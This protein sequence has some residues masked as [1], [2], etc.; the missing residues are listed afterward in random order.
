MSAAASIDAAARV[1]EEQV[2]PAIRLPLRLDVRLTKNWP[3]MKCLQ[4]RV[5]QVSDFTNEG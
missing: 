2:A 4:A 1:S 5:F 3:E